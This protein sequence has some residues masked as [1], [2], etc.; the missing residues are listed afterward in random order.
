MLKN[1]DTVGFISGHGS[2]HE[3]TIDAIDW[4]NDDSKQAFGGKGIKLADQDQLLCKN[5]SVRAMTRAPRRQHFMSL[6]GLSVAIDNGENDNYQLVHPTDKDLEMYQVGLKV[7]W[8]KY[9]YRNWTPGEITKIDRDTKNPTR[10]I[11]VNDS[12][13]FHPWNFD[14]LRPL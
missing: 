11:V 9:E 7:E 3:Y 12:R 4:V 2:H 14:C 8:K 10:M 6:D 5:K 13:R 1:G